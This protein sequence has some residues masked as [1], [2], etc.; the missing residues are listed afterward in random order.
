MSHFRMRHEI[1]CHENRIYGMSL[2]NYHE[3][4]PCEVFDLARR[5]WIPIPSPRNDQRIRYPYIL[6][7]QAAH[8]QIVAIG[9]TAKGELGYMKCDAVEGRWLDTKSFPGLYERISSPLKIYQFLHPSYCSY[10]SMGDRLT[11]HTYSL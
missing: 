2:S 7:A 10:A 4:Q 6:F 1:V 5:T 9:M 3:N 8:D 11:L